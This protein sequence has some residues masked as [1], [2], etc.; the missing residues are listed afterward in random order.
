MIFS[1]PAAEL[2]ITHLS[3]AFRFL[4]PNPSRYYCAPSF[5][6][7]DKPEYDS[8]TFSG[9]VNM[10]D[11]Y[12]ARVSFSCD[13]DGKIYENTLATCEARGRLNAPTVGCAFGL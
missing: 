2:L 12:M 4:T 6:N 9:M 7:M 13:N 1:V 8:F 11:S 10:T 5:I 3:V